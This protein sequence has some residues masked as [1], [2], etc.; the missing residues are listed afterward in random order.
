MHKMTADNQNHS[1]T[2][3]LLEYVLVALC[4]ASTVLL[5]SWLIRYGAY[6]ID[7][8]DESFYL[9][10]IFNPFIFDFSRTQFG[11]V[12]HPL[13]SLFGGDIVTIRQANVIITLVLAW[14]MAYFFLASLAPRIKG[15]QI[16]LFVASSGFA[17]TAFIL[18]GTWLLTPNYNSLALQALLVTVTGL[19]L[20]DKNAHRKSVI[21][22]L[23][24]G[25]GGWLAFM[26][27]PST[28]LALAVGAL[29]YLLFAR[30]LT[31]RLLALAAT[32][33]L[34]LILVSA[35]LIDGSLWGFVKRIQRGMEIGQVLTDKLSN[36]FRIDNFYLVDKA[37]TA[38]YIISAT[39][40]VAMGSICAKS[41][42]WSFIGLLVSVALFAITAL[43]TLDQIHPDAGLGQ[44]QALLVFG[45]VY[46]MTLTALAF[47]RLNALRG[48]SAPQW[49]I[50]ALFLV[51]PH[52][53]AFGTGG[54]YW[55][56]GSQAAIFWILAG[57]TILG[58]LIRERDSWLLVLPIVLAAQAV[59]AILL[60]TALEQ[61][62]RQPQPLRL[63]DTTIEFGPERSMLRLS[64]GYAAYMNDVTATARNAN[65][66]AGTSVIDLTGQS[67]GVL[68]AMAAKSIGH[69]W[70][71]GG[72]PGS[73]PFL[74]A[75]LSRFSCEDI[76]TAWVLFEP[77]GPRSISDT[78]LPSF[79]V[80][81][82]SEY[83]RIGTWNTA[84]GAGGYEASRTQE[85]YKPINSQKSLMA[86]NSLRP[87]VTGEQK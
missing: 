45:L 66:K 4:A 87:K 70:T 15:S 30:K 61:P 72:Y 81:F 33:A 34:G 17:T 3:T 27:K 8:T 54:N 19:V 14:V 38:V 23:L 5:T 84:K 49:A 50:A 80:V 69:P 86:C 43:L 75:G 25:A 74:E 20:A 83:A 57:L 28:A 56:S 53:Y 48:I 7:F 11:F 18:F 21:G 13:Y 67:P 16:T 60:Q 32:S 44:F 58:P 85:L 41:K 65:F 77:D 52:I 46:A 1:A 79:G 62:Y 71:L 40:F 37:K 82:P 78:I 2:N 36:I 29:L 35:L 68:F 51:M 64:A 6:G 24:I 22:W 76:A 55:Q 39:L 9:V 73:L 12:Y 59:T 63:N 42:K 47:G 26:A 31:F 10:W